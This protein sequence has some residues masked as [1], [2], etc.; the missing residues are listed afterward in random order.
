MSNKRETV[1][2]TPN[3]S[4]KKKK[5]EADD[6]FPVGEKIFCLF[7]RDNTYR[8]CKVIDRN[9]ESKMYYVNWIEFV[10]ECFRFY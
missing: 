8:L 7:R 5:D 4:N 2:D 9:T 10:S 3:K 1:D 6:M